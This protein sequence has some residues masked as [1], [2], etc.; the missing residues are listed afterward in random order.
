[1]RLTDWMNS[2]VRKLN[3]IDVRMITLS[4]AAFIL[5]VA[6]LWPPILS[7]PWYWYLVIA[8]LAAIR[9]VYKAFIKSS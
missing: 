5:M 1:M 9:P 4:T 2:K 7:L 6:K 8:I 3:W